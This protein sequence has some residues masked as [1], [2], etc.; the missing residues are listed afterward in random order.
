M[1]GQ[2]LGN[3]VVLAELGRG[4]MGDVYV[5]LDT[6]LD[7]RVALKLPRRDVSASSI[8]SRCFSEK[9]KL[10]PP[11]TIPISCTS[12]PWRKLTV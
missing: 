3:Y 9:P 11:S 6:R 5:A 4:G 1:I 7:R 10:R 12:T 2:R 8:V